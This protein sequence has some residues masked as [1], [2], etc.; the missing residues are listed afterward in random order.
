MSITANDKKT[1]IIEIIGPPGAGK[2]TI[3]KA[4]C[5]EWNSGC[6]WI[7]QEKLLAK[8][9]HSIYSPA[10]WMESKLK[11]LLNKH[12]GQTIA[13][14]YGIRFTETNRKTANY[15]WNYLD[16][17]VD[18]EDGSA[19]QKFRA[20]YFLF[21]DYSR[22]QAIWEKNSAMPCIIDEGLLE[23]SFFVTNSNDKMKEIMDAYLEIVPLPTTL[24]YI[25]IDEPGKIV[26]RLLTRPKTIASHTGKNREELIRNI[27]NWQKLFNII[28]GKLLEKNIPVYRL[29]GMLPIN[30]NVQKLKQIL[31]RF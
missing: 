29:D 11:S 24:I 21:K 7:Y 20:A 25:D 28:T 12:N 26:E 31:S 8:N 2:T 3:Y 10:R 14:E 1:K 22:Y 16:K 27:E 18:T 19:G 5:K 4:L 30:Q 17:N 13:V 15:L 23:K 6:N 9:Q